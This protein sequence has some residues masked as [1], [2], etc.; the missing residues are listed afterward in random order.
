MRCTSEERDT[1]RGLAE[2]KAAIAALPRH[3]ET[4]AE[5]RRLNARAPGRPLVWINEIPWNEMDVDGRLQLRCE[6]PFLRTVEWTLRAEIYQWEH[7][8]GDMVVEPTL[9]CPLAIHDTGMGIAPD[10]HV[11]A[12]D[13]TSAVVS[14]EYH[15]QFACEEDLDRIRDPVVTHDTEASQE[16]LETL[17][18]LLGDIL[19]VE[20]RGII[21]TWFAPWDEL[22]QWWGVQQAMTDLVDRPGLVHAGMDRLVNAHLARLRQ[23]REQNLLSWSEG[24]HRVGSGGLGYADDLPSPSFDPQHVT[25]RDQW[26][27]ATAQIF[28]EVS[29]RMHEE[30]ALAYE[31]RWLREFGLNYYGC[32]E[33]L[34][35]KIPILSA[36]PNLRKVSMSPRANVA[37]MA[38]Q[39]G[40]RYVL[41]HKPN[42]AIL[43]EDVWNP[44][45]ARAELRSVLETCRGCTVEII[46]KDI[47]TVRYEPRR[48]WE[49]AQI[50]VEEAE[51][52]AP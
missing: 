36:I 12:T 1:L 40:D 3:R 7:L 43:A 32:C 37:L 20:P 25:T 11:V 49:W 33:P 10:V 51:R 34:H 22:V 15:G 30:F 41:S 45:A 8:P 21:H 2:R 35:T 52:Y 44:D 38:A 47:S 23:W 18:S 48:L 5:W 28:S 17:Q 14:R 39:A 4:I 46:M 13:P 42:P 29:P 50:A 31:L 24:N 16:R 9:P 19:R 27:C 26:G 6:D